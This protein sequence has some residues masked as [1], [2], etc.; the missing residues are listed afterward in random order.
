MSVQIVH[1]A[2]RACVDQSLW[3]W[4]VAV[5]N[6][7]WKLLS[8]SVSSGSPSVFSP[9]PY[10]A[11]ASSCL[12][13][14]GT[15]DPRFIPSLELSE[16][17]EVLRRCWRT[18]PRPN[19]LLEGIDRTRSCSLLP[20]PSGFALQRSGCPGRVFLRACRRN[21]VLLPCL[22]GVPST[23]NV[24]KLLGYQHTS[25][26]PLTLPDG[27]HKKL[28]LPRHVV[29]LQKKNLYGFSEMTYRDCTSPRVFRRFLQL[30]T[31]PL[32]I[33]RIFYAHHCCVTRAN[34]SLRH[35]LFCA[36]KCCELCVTS[37]RQKLKNTCTAL[38]IMV[39][40]AAHS[41]GTVQ[42]FAQTS[43]RCRDPCKRSLIPSPVCQGEVG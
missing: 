42:P 10:S 14:P 33:N 24:K 15:C 36:E 29:F 21:A 26:H 3:R 23:P 28:F 32:H 39:R 20:V 27:R 41:A 13:E 34:V 5:R 4:C 31:I 30:I 7:I 6:R 8:A 43:H 37:C 16:L 40:T 25:T 1:H 17:L 2:R 38:A 18:A 11:D 19:L 9:S 12:T 22:L 35:V